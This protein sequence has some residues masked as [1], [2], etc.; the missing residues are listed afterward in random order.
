[1]KLYCN[2]VSPTSLSVM[3]FCAEARIPFEPVVID[4]MK[5]QQKTPDYLTLNPW[6][7]VPVLEDDDFV[8]TESSAILKYLADKAKLPAYPH[9]LRERAR[10]NEVSDGVAASLASTQFVPLLA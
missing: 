2:P 7:L 3:L 5:S 10:V 9:G 8:L 1:M 4:L 6:G